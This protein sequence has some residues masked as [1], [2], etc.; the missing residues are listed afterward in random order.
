MRICLVI[1]SLG[2]GGAERVAST[3]ANEW[4]RD[5][6]ETSVVTF[7]TLGRGFYQLDPRIDRRDLDLMRQSSGIVSAIMAN[8]SRLRRL[9]LEFRSIRPDVIVSFIDSMNVLVLLAAAGLEIPVVVSERTDPRAAALG[10]AWQALRRV[11]YR[12]AAALVVQT[13]SVAMWARDIVDSRRVV[14]VPNPINES[15]FQAERRGRFGTRVRRVVALGRLLPEKGFDLLIEAFARA[16]AD[17]PDWSLVIAGAGRLDSALREQADRT[18]CADRVTFPGLVTQP[19]ELLAA[20]EI[21]VLSSRLEGFPNALVEAMACGCSVIATDCRSGPAEIITDDVDGILAAVGDIDAIAKTLD[22]L[23]SS[24]ATRARLGTAAAQSAERF[25]AER[26]AE[27]WIRLLES[28]SA[29]TTV[30][31]PPPADSPQFSL[32]R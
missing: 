32:E 18:P 3:L 29:G 24:V 11:A 6:H 2:C 9:R 20:S 7:A 4:T 27:Q 15:C 28:V 30:L 1:N 8:V 19:E 21:F 22:E 31:A 14:V 17:H 13:E 10:S 16:S 12:R 25:R 26:I 5:G 23:M